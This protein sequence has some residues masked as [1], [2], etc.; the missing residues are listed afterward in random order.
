MKPLSFLRLLQVFDSQFPVGAF[1]HSGGLETYGHLPLDARGLGRLMGNQVRLGWGRL[2]L[3][4]ACLAW[5][6]CDKS[7]VLEGLCEEV[8]ASKNHSGTTEQ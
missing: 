8:D 1:V 6:S 2:D 4:A 5:R 7:E 3:A